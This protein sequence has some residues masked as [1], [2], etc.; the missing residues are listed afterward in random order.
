MTDQPTFHIPEPPGFRKPD[1]TWAT[2]SLD[3]NEIKLLADPARATLLDVLNYNEASVKEL[4]AK[5]APVAAVYLT[6]LQ[7]ATKTGEHGPI[8]TDP[9]KTVP[10]SEAEGGPAVMFTEMTLHTDYLFDLSTLGKIPCLGVGRDPRNAFRPALPVG[11]PS[12]KEGFDVHISREHGL[13]YLDSTGGKKVIR[14]RDRG[15]FQQG[16]M[17][18]TW[19]DG[20]ERVKDTIIEWTNGTYLGFGTRE[21][22]SGERVHLF[23]LRYKLL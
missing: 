11:H 18:G 4:T 21:T 2:T 3:A 17:N 8:V 6:R 14:Y 15:T 19:I 20:K 7:I 10:L 12:H 1:A 9:D 5:T 22:V 16:S 13:I 23:K